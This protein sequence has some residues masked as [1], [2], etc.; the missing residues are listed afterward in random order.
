MAER[1]C[2]KRRCNS[3]LAAFSGAQAGTL[4]YD[5]LGR[6]RQ[7]TTGGV[8][9]DWLWDGDKLVAEYVSGTLTASYAHGPGP[10][11][12]LAVT[13]SGVRRWFQADHQNTTIALAD[14]TGAIVGSPYTYDAYGQPSGGTFS[15]PRF[16]FTGQTSLPGAPPLWHY[17]A[18]AYAPGIGRFLQTDPIG[19]EDS[20]NLYAYVGNDPFNRVDPSGTQ[21]ELVGGRWA[22]HFDKVI[23]GPPTD[24][25]NRQIAN[26]SGDYT[27]IVNH[28]MDN[29]TL[30]ASTMVPDDNGGMRE[31]TITAEQLGRELIGR[32][33][34]VDLGDSGIDSSGV[35]GAQ[36]SYDNPEV[37]T[38]TRA[39]LE[40]H[41]AFGQT[42]R[43]S[44]VNV[45]AHEGIHGSNSERRVFDPYLSS[46][47][48]TDSHN[49]PY[50]S[51][52]DQL[53]RPR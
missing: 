32:D 40:G 34:H 10:D 17:K 46:S 15:G 47:L 29:P 24:E 52:I 33:F 35:T 44:R 31:V 53:L 14:S 43:D 26:F 48:Q 37:T 49:A 51:L 41:R 8:T 6:L 19:Y 28:L 2:S 3:A 23:G 12:P 4:L 45:I 7:V 27:A 38:V 50:Q 30:T 11:E 5:P 22:C 39:G 18:R 20:L 9:T 25:Q 21:C 16:R 36:T 13:A 42:S 1:A